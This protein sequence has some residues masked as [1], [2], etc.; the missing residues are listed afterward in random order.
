MQSKM[1]NLTETF[2]VYFFY[3]KAS[4]CEINSMQYKSVAESLFNSIKKSSENDEK[5]LVPHLDLL[6]N[7]FCQN[8][9]ISLRGF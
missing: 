5:I 3:R 8:P 4:S 9:R 6:V 1:Q 7:K 2:I